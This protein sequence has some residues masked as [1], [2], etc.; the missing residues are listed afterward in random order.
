MK[1]QIRILLIWVCLFAGCNENSR[2]IDTPTSGE[3]NISV[4]ESIARIIESEVSTFQKIYPGTKI[5]VHYK[6]EAEL[7]NDLISDSSRLIIAAR[8]LNDDETEYFK[9]LEIVPS[10]TRICYDAVAVIVNNK[11]IDTLISLNKLK[12]I[13]SGKILKWSEAGKSGNNNKIQIV[14][15]NSSSSTLRYIRELTE[16]Q[17][18]PNSFAVKTNP[19]VIS[20]VSNNADA[21]GIIG[22]NWISD[23]DDSVTNKF[24]TTV[25]VVGIKSDL[26]NV[27]PREYYQPYQAY[28][29]MKYYPLIREYY[30]ISREAYT[31]LGS[32][33]AAF[34]A[35]EKGQR[36]FLKSGLVPATMP[37][38]LVETYQ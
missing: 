21:V 5:N 30:I 6:P 31:G 18:S 11:N 26:P 4:D 25:R 22:V 1:K 3:I 12:G 19:E 32:G 27:D 36:I 14:Y 37:V 38:R 28:I 9:K 7:F 10:T 15:D 33:F 13:L 2:M 8:K 17:L 24:L 20:Y 23:R 34:V 29:A 16:N 35:G